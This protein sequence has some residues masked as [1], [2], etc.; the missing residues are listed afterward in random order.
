MAPGANVPQAVTGL[1][2]RPIARERVRQR[3]ADYIKEQILEGKIGIGARIPQDEIARVLGVSNTPVREAVIALEHEGIVTIQHHRG[4]FVN[5]FDRRSIAGNYELWALL[6]GWA[7]RRAMSS[8][9]EDK[10]ELS[11]LAREIRDATAL[12]DIRPLMTRF[13][14]KLGLMCDSQAWRHLLDAIPRLVAADAYYAVVPGMGESASK[15]MA[16]IAKAVDRSDGDAAAVASENMLR[17]H[18]NCLIAELER[19]GLFR[20]EAAASK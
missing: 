3:I 2:A 16:K 5:D 20:P 19:R 1:P 10:L 7:I 14:D 11:A 8:S 13:V 12:D 9:T 18:G 6:Y 4:A 15:W 17:E